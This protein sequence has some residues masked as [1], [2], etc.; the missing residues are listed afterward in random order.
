MSLKK[1]NI[2]VNWVQSDK[3]E[4]F[5]NAID[6]KTKAIYVESIANP[7]YTVAPLPQLAKVPSSNPYVGTQS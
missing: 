6:D 4:D 3:P 2:G 1:F 7:K 5:E